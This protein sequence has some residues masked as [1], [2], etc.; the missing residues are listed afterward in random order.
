[1]SRD[2]IHQRIDELLGLLSNHNNRLSLH[3]EKLSQLDIDALRKQCINVYDEVNRLAL[4]GRIKS[5]TPTVPD[6]QEVSAVKHTPD[7]S[8]FSEPVKPAIS[9]PLVNT[10]IRHKAKADEE[11]LSLFEKF[12]SKPIESITKGMSV[13]KRFEFQSALFD[14][15]HKEYNHFIGQLESAG[16]LESAFEV[17]QTYKTKLEWDSED[18]KDELKALMYRKYR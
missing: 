14:G 11:M 12:S 1:M 7:P 8:S 15:D 6:P 2:S 16:D 13:A 9:E 18:L 17:Y 3:S 10:L 5:K 4:H